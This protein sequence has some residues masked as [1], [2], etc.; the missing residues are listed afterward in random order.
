MHVF[1]AKR[2]VYLHVH[3]NNAT[4][5]NTRVR[6][7]RVRCV[8]PTPRHIQECAASNIVGL[9]EDSFLSFGGRNVRSGTRIEAADE[10]GEV[11]DGG[12]GKGHAE[13]DENDREDRFRL[14]CGDNISE[15]NSDLR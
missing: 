6:V 2:A 14:C 8:V 10:E 11:G 9:Q 15:P 13:V 3:G 5:L 4:I 12:G 7:S 1:S